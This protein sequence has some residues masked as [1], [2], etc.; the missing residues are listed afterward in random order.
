MTQEF[1]CLE[2]GSECF[3]LGITSHWLDNLP[4]WV[5]SPGYECDDCGCV[6]M[7]ADQMTI[8][9]ASTLKAEIDYY[10]KQLQKSKDPDTEFRLAESKRRFDALES[11]LK[12]SESSEDNN[13][14][15][16]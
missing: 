9:R 15:I 4:T 1:T 10:T 12:K 13:R 11:A 14:P 2:C 7:T 3:T 5:Y 16:S 6:L 8:F